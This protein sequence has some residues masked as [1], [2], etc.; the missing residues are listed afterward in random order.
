MCGMESDWRLTALI[1]Q[2]YRLKLRLRNYKQKH[3]QAMQSLPFEFH[4]VT[5]HFFQL[6]QGMNNSEVSA[7][8]HAM[9]FAEE[10]RDTLVSRHE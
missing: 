4:Y 7:L 5:V 8:N 3:R 9:N 1:F 2:A 6:N 10:L